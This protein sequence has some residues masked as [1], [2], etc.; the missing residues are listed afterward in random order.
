MSLEELKKQIPFKWRVQSFSKSSQTA[1]CVAY[2]DARDVMDILDQVVGTENWQSDF[3]EIKGNLYAGVGIRLNN[4]IEWVWKWDCGTESNTEKEKGEA[5]DAFKR[6]AVKWGVGRFLYDIPIQYVKSNEKKTD[7]NYPFVVDDNGAKVWDITKF[8]NDKMGNKNT[9]QQKQQVKKQEP[10]TVQVS[11][12]IIDIQ[13]KK[14]Q[15]QMQMQMQMQKDFIAVKNK[16]VF[17]WAN[18]VKKWL[19]KKPEL[20]GSES[21]DKWALK[22]KPEAKDEVNA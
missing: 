10:P 18:V 5:S 22:Y 15:E 7:K 16:T 20:A 13:K 2:V 6:A 11:E 8:I 12:N 14:E 4:S 21:F 19:D 3:K 9:T 17:D 1:S